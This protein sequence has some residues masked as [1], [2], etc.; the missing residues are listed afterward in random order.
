M[1]EMNL[2]KIKL[3]ASISHKLRTPLNCSLSM[4]QMISN[5]PEITP[6]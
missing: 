3:I 2:L 6:E 5:I 1:K 4:L